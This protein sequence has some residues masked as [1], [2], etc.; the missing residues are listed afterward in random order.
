MSAEV[1]KKKDR[2]WVVDLLIDA[3]ELLLFIPRGI[4]RI[5]KDII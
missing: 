2:W 5:I 4:F 1:R 3:G